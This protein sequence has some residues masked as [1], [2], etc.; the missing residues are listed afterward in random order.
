MDKE[1]AIEEI[2]DWSK[3]HQLISSSKKSVKPQDLI[4]IKVPGFENVSSGIDT[5]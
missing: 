1:C 2:K 3:T 5:I 4:W